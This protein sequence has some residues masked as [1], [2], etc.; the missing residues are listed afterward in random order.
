MGHL[1]KR[2]GN[3]GGGLLPTIENSDDVIK[4]AK[5]F[6]PNSKTIL[7]FST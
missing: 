4:M 3:S 2:D 5:K 6:V 1:G 7:D